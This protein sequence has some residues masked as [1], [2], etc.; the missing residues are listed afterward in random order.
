[1]NETTKAKR[2]RGLETAE[3]ILEVSAQLFAEKGFDSI[4]TREIAA[5]VGIKDSSIYNH[6]KSK[7]EILDTLFERFAAGIPV[8]RPTGDEAAELIAL[9]SPGELLKHLIIRYGRSINTLVNNTAKIIYSEMFR[10]EKAQVLFKR[11]LLED[12]IAFYKN[13]FQLM[14]THGHFAD[15]DTDPLAECYSN[16]LLT[17]TIQY[18]GV[19]DKPE[20]AL[21]ISQ[22]MMKMAEFICSLTAYKGVSK[23]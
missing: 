18:A 10:N 22:K 19:S 3:R 7:S 17:L 8:S 13:L 1:M 4:S 20:E 21:A 14:K 11:V 5:A 9:L 12:Q 2:R 16:S 15:I 23:K 6:F